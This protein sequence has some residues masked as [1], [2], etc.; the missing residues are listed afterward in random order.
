MRNLVQ[1]IRTKGGILKVVNMLAVT[2]L[3][4]S[5]NVTCMWVQHQPEAPEDL[6]KFRKF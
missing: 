4:Y 1:K 6:R 2:L 3:I 5:A